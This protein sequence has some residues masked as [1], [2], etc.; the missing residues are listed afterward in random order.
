MSTEKRRLLFGFGS[1]FAALGKEQPKNIPKIPPSARG[2]G[3]LGASAG[4]LLSAA[5]V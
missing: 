4:R 3:Q 5:Q 1:D 2:L